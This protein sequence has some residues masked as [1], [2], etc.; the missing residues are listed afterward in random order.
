MKLEAAEANA[1][2]PRIKELS[3]EDIT[4]TFWNLILGVFTVIVAGVVM[5]G[6]E[7][8]IAQAQSKND[9]ALA[10]RF[11]GMWRLVSWTQR[12][13]DGTTRQNPLSVAYLIYTDTD[14]MCYVAMNPDRPKWKTPTAPTESEALSGINGVGAYCAKVEIHA[15]QGFVLH[16]VEIDRVPNNLGITRKRWF[17]FEGPNRVSLRIDAA[18]TIPPVVE[19]TLIWERVTK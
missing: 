11:V 12:L 10:S 18:E 16:H 1:L 13:A 3:D 19:S 15:S 5:L 6:G 8:V 14:R 17:T 4:D 9:E 7:R 2:F